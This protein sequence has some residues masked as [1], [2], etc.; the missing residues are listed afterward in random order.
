MTQKICKKTNWFPFNIKPIHIGVYETKGWG[1]VTIWSK[2]DGKQWLG[3]R[4]EFDSAKDSFTSSNYQNRKWR[5]C[6]EKL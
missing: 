6:K 3:D 2:W 4:W 1:N 5:G